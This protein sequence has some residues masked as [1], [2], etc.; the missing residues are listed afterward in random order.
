MYEN[1]LEAA[2]AALAASGAIVPQPAPYIAG[3]DAGLLAPGEEAM[4]DLSNPP[5]VAIPDRLTAYRGDVPPRGTPQRP[6]YPV[7]VDRF[8]A[9]LGQPDLADVPR[10]PVDPYPGVRDPYSDVPRFGYGDVAAADRA[11]SDQINQVGRSRADLADAQIRSQADLLSRQ[12]A[13]QE[14]GVREMQR[15][16][17]DYQAARATAEAKADQETAQWLEQVTTLAQK[18][19]SPDRWWDTRSS[20]GKALWGLGL[21]F[22]TIHA[23]ITPG[24]KN[25]VL[26]M[27]KQEI[28]N[29]VERQQQRLEREMQ[30]L[31][32][33]GQ[34]MDK[35]Q[36]RL[37][38]DMQDDH[39]MRLT[40]I[41]ALEKAWLTRAATPGDPQKA[42]ALA[43][44]QMFLDE[45]KL[46]VIGKRRDV[47]VQQ[48]N[49]ALDR[50]HA[51]RLKGMEIAQR[52]REA[53]QQQKQFDDELDYKYWK[54]KTDAAVTLATRPAG[55]D[56]L[57]DK[58]GVAFDTGAV[59][60]GPDGQPVGDGTFYVRD[61]KAHQE[62][63]EIT[64]SA[65]KLYRDLNRLAEKLEEKGVAA[66]A[67]GVAIGETDPEIQKLV[68]DIAYGTA[69]QLDPGGRLSEMDVLKGGMAKF[70]F[71]PDGKLLDRAKH[72]WDPS[73]IANMIR[74]ETK[75]MEVEVGKKLAKYNDVSLNGQRTR[76]LWR[77]Q[78]IEAPKVPDRTSVDD[79]I[80]AG[81]Y[82]PPAPPTSAKEYD[83]KLAQ[84][85]TQR[86]LRGVLLP[87]HD[88]TEV[89]AARA[90][91]EGKGPDKIRD[92]AARALAAAKDENT[93]Q[94]IL[95]ISKD[96]EEKAAKTLAQLEKDVNQFNEARRLKKQKPISG[97]YIPEPLSLKD[98]QSLATRRGLGN[99]GEAIQELY[100]RVS[101]NAA[102]IIRRTAIKRANQ[103]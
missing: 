92:A 50:T 15:A 74:E 85:Q 22:S 75:N 56:K 31:K 45:L 62:V 68:T 81:T 94:M 77:P 25:A 96:A 101:G 59:M 51:T 13:V 58:R 90:S 70:G 39:T 20:F 26:E 80:K 2:L 97:G 49:S 46:G 7:G 18:E 8:G 99:D 14:Q 11:E 83:A 66:R 84:E 103:K 67:A 12:A 82:V 41:Q 65:S 55:S 1:P 72:N 44:S 36:A 52:Q 17:M 63:G 19:P 34:V 33:T 54:E 71:G 40:R 60:V 16:D 86:G 28:N 35:R 69:K 64:T 78:N 88:R 87:L 102:E 30:A 91:F 100:D 53:L 79:S 6:D 48:Q 43:E 4:Y 37:L 24:A 73:A 3:G 42:A 95:V 5:G 47:A 61:E 57:P 23:G 32:L 9:E 21:V 93:R 10:A 29:D 38:S 76:V 27:V 89:A 98:V